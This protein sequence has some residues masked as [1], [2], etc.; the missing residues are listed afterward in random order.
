MNKQ[1]VLIGRVP[2]V[3]K[4]NKDAP[5]IDLYVN[6]NNVAYV[7]PAIYPIFKPGEIYVHNKPPEKFIC[8]GTIVVLT[9]ENTAAIVGNSIY[10][11]PK[12]HQN[13]IFTNVKTESVVEIL[14]GNKSY[15]DLKESDIYDIPDKDI[16]DRMG[17][18]L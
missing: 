9:V 6:P 13:R 10:G 16:Q 7:K 1:V 8:L 2:V 14:N 12:I 3:T 15:N 18:C 11:N 17:Q 4:G 5:L